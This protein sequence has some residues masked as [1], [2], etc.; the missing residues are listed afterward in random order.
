MRLS[1]RTKITLALLVTGLVSAVLVGVIARLTFLQQFNRAIF[2]E[3][4]LA[5]SGDVTAYVEAYGSL[6]AAL[7][8]EPFPQFVLRRRESISAPARTVGADA[9]RIGGPGFIPPFFFIALD[10]QGRPVIGGPRPEGRP[11]VTPELRARARSIVVAG[12]TVAY[13]V[14]IEQPNFNAVDQTYLDAMQHAMGYGIAGATLIALALGFFFSHRLSANLRALARAIQA[15][16]SG[17]LRQHVHVRARDEV[18]VLG[19][20]F[21]RLSEELAHSHD[22]I[23]QQAEQL[24]ELSIRDETTL[25]HNRRYFN[26]QAT[27]AYWQA[28]RYGRPFSLCVADIDHFKQINDRFSHATGDAVLRQIGR[29]LAASMRE[30]DIV[31]RYGGEEFVMAFPETPLA[32]AFATCER[33]RRAIE[34]HPWHEVH[35]EL[36][37]TMTVGIDSDVSRVQLEQMIVAADERLYEGKRCGR[38]RVVCGTEERTTW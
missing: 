12:D 3:S 2:E 21:N 30:S 5:F 16:R 13:A 23:Q 18:G 29:I 19:D 27:I 6:E 26:E 33:I 20:A 15:M 22:T 37:V 28:Q 24:R 10:L 38:N 4:F 36:S 25:L 11:D 32:E 1:L 8:A 35:P 7:Q 31:A 17:E 34:E 14:P 9:G